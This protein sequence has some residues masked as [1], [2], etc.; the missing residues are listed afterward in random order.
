[1]VVVFPDNIFKYASSVLRH[2]PDLRPAEKEEAQATAI[3]KGDELLAEMMENLKNPHDSI[4]AK[5]LGREL[6]SGAPPLVIDIRIPEHYHDKHV[7]GSINIPQ[8]DL[9]ARKG[10]LP[11]DRDAPIVTVCN[12]GKFSKQA[13][14][15]LKSMGYRNVKS[16][17]GGLA[18]W[19]R[20]G[21]ETDPHSITAA[22][23]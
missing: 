19:I 22:A 9:K 15:Y 1:M 11:D 18:E 2:F 8:D 10:E 17:K 3:S 12:I 6:S 16:L 4:K 21:L 7:P 23:G 5:D 20:K 14:L 13:T